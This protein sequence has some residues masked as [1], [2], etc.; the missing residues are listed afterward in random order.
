MNFSLGEFNIVCTNLENSIRFYRD[1]MNFE[2]IERAETYA[3][4]KCDKQTLT[5]LA[6]AENQNEKLPYGTN[7]T[8]SLDLLVDDLKQASNYFTSNGVEIAM[9]LNEDKGYFAIYDPDMLIWEIVE[10]S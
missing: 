1:I 8:F 6:F 10:R 4:F 5:L 9:T 2:L 7:A 3:H